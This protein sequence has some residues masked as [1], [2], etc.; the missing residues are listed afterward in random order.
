MGF[1]I[2]IKAAKSFTPVQRSMME[3]LSHLGYLHNQIK[4]HCDDMDKQM[5][6]IGQ[7]LIAVLREK[8]V[9]YY[10]LLAVLQANVRL[11]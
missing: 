11:I 9:E 3:R 10:Q 1:T 2:D 4:Q 7:S 8:L 5:G 6:V